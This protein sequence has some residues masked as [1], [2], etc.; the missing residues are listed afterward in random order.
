MSRVGATLRQKDKN[1]HTH[2]DSVIPDEGVSTLL[3]ALRDTPRYDCNIN[4][5]MFHS[6]RGTCVM[7]LLSYSKYSELYDDALQTVSTLKRIHV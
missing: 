3:T 6:Q 2:I 1:T 5:I 4:T 7:F